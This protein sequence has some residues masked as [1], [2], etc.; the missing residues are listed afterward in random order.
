[1]HAFPGA[2][3]IEA[4]ELLG[5]LHR[6]VDHAL[7]LVVVAHLD[8]AGQR[9]VL[10]QRMALEAVVGEDAAQIGMV[11]EED[12]VHVEGLALEPV[13]RFQKTGD[14]D[15]TGVSSSVRN[16]T[17]RRWLCLQRQQ[18]IDDLEALRAPG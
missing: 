6:L 17:R 12:A 16:L 3:E 2:E 9:E 1:M 10:A 11:G 8:I 7:L 13:R 14:T 5:Q 4:A 18:V 15:G